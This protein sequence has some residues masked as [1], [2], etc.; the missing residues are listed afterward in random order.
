MWSS[1]RLATPIN[2]KDSKSLL[3]KLKTSTLLSFNFKI[4][5][6]IFQMPKFRPCF[7]IPCSSPLRNNTGWT[8][9]IRT[10][11][12]DSITSGTNFS[13]QQMH[14]EYSL[15]QS[16]RHF[17]T[18]CLSHTNPSVQQTFISEKLNIEWS[19]YSTLVYPK[20]HLPRLNAC[21]FSLAWQQEQMF[22]MRRRS[23]PSRKGEK[24]ENYNVMW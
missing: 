22:S 9:I 6:I 5:W 24:K 17:S 7:R 16:T 14:Q 11:R 18:K 13:H 15:K 12:L 8:I 23:R 21:L 3:T 2:L 4:I 19:S 1:T 20:H 10:N